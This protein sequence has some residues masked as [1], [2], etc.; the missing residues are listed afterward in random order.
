LFER[1]R[2]EKSGGWDADFERVRMTVD[3]YRVAAG[4]APARPALCV[5]TLLLAVSANALLRYRS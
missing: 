2:F 1:Y 5:S 4:Y 3:G